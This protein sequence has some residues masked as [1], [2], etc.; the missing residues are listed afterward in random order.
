MLAAGDINGDGYQ[1]L[2]MPNSGGI[3]HY[4]SV[5]GGAANG[6]YAY[7]QAI[8]ELPVADGGGTNRNRYSRL[9]DLN[10]DGSDDFLYSYPA[11]SGFGDGGAV[12]VYLGRDTDPWPSDADDL[13]LI[14]YGEGITNKAVT[15]DVD[16]DGKIDL[17]IKVQSFNVA[18]IKN[19]YLTFSGGTRELGVG[20]Y[21]PRWS[22]GSYWTEMGDITND[23]HTDFAAMIG[24]KMEIMDGKSIREAGN[25]VS[26]SREHVLSIIDTGADT[27]GATGVTSPIPTTDLNGDGVGESFVALNGT[28]DFYGAIVFS[29]A[30]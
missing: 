24:D 26:N 29:P 3:R 22:L 23:G 2:L 15:G 8:Q 16:E 19:E 30:P 10:E 13:E 28:T 12:W 1:D 14:F 6:Y 25:I 21:G 20:V 9:G 5:T 11:K 17:F 4:S 27:A 7:A 18:W